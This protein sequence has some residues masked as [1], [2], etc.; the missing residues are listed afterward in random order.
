[1]HMAASITYDANR[2]PSLEMT[3][4]LLLNVDSMDTVLIG[5]LSKSFV[6]TLRIGKVFEFAFHQSKTSWFFFLSGLNNIQSTLLISRSFVIIHFLLWHPT[7]AQEDPHFNLKYLLK[8][9]HCVDFC[10][11]YIL[12]YTTYTYFLTKF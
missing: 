3:R 6:I 10:N 1:M 8:M 12:Y 9:W 2:F 7:L 5:G 11:D 4:P